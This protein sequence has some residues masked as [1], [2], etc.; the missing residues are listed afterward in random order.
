MT[1]HTAEHLYSILFVYFYT[2]IRIAF[3]ILDILSYTIKQ[4]HYKPET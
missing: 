1:N 3:D 4:S 2:F